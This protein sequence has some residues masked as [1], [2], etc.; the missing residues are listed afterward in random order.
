[1]D[2][3]L[4]SP[5]F[6]GLAPFVVALIVLLL[7]RRLRPAWSALAVTLGLLS[8]ILLVNGLT[9]TPLT[10][11]RK[12][13][14]IGLCAGPVGL[15]VAA[16]LRGRVQAVLFPVAAALATVWVFWIVLSRKSGVELALLGIGSIAYVVVLVSSLQTL[17]E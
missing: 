1:M 16:V 4:A 12:I 5:E 10:G 17:A 6:Q 13:M 3:L 11:T 15:A 9:V 14:L 2:R 7:L 8:T